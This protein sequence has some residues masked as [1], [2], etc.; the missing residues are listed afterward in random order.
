M[1]P[2]SPTPSDTPMNPAKQAKW[3]LISH[4]LDKVVWEQDYK[5]SS[6]GATRLLHRLA[7][8][9]TDDLLLELYLVNAETGQPFIRPL[10]TLRGTVTNYSLG[11]WTKKPLGL[12]YMQGRGAS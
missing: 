7:K 1:V 5:G 3:K 12:G 11:N 10:L 4:N 6:K 9:A 2:P 8:K